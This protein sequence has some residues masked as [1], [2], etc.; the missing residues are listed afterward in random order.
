MTKRRPAPR[1]WQGHDH[2]R[3]SACER[4]AAH[5]A[6]L[7][8]ALEAAQDVIHRSFCKP[9]GGECWKECRKAREAWHAAQEAAP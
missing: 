2:W 6:P 9:D 1:P 3:C 7:M 4:D 5:V 8:E